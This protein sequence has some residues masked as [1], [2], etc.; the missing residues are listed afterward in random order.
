M[1]GIIAWREYYQNTLRI[2]KR[3]ISKVE[4]EERNE[5]I[6]YICVSYRESRSVEKWN[7]NIGLVRKTESSDSTEWLKKNI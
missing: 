3:S 1:F 6:W 7:N 4:R 2:M 5:F